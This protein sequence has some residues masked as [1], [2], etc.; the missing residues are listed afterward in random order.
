MVKFASFRDVVL[1][2]QAA[3]VLHPSVLYKE[4][5]TTI[6]TLDDEEKNLL[7]DA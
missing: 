2:F 6:T 4:A 5:M 3:L 7:G 1:A